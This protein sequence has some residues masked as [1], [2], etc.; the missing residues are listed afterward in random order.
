MFLSVLGLCL[1]PSEARMYT[2]CV[3]NKRPG[4]CNIMRPCHNELFMWISDRREAAARHSAEPLGRPSASFLDCMKSS[5]IFRPFSTRGHVIYQMNGPLF[6]TVEPL[7]VHHATRQVSPQYCFSLP[8]TVFSWHICIP[9]GVRRERGT[10]T[11]IT[12]RETVYGFC[13]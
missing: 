11:I 12:M 9:S 4:S 2:C 7:T 13:Y 8:R 3:S 1:P 6:W 5:Q 10:I